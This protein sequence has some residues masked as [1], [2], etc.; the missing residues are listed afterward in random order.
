MELY[1]IEWQ[2]HFSISS[3]HPKLRTSLASYLSI[4]LTIHLFVFLLCCRTIKWVTVTRFAIDGDDE[5]ECFGL[6]LCNFFAPQFNVH[7][8]T[9]A[10]PKRTF[11]EKQMCTS[12]EIVWRGGGREREWTKK[13]ATRE[14]RFTKSFD[15][16]CFCELW[17]TRRGGVFFLN[18]FSF[19]LSRPLTSITKTL[20]F[21]LNPD[22]NWCVCVFFA[23]SEW[24]LYARITWINVCQCSFALAECC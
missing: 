15:R 21:L 22:F 7:A 2:A 23:H 8:I 12:I 19:T 17:L 3:I 14:K 11:D 10:I 4:Y 16:V 1:G 18:S 9:A 13:R 24:I 20:S 5:T 6:E